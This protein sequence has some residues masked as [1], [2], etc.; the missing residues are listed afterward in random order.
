M[1]PEDAFMAA[2]IESPEDDGPRL[3]YADWL[4]DH[5]QPERAEFIRLQCELASMSEDE[6]V[7]RRQEPEARE[8][9]LLE[10]H[11]EG[12]AGPLRKVVRKWKFRRGFV[13]EIEIETGDFLAHAGA[14]L[15]LAPVRQ[16]AFD[17]WSPVD[18]TL[19]RLAACDALARLAAVRLAFGH[20]ECSDHTLRTLASLPPLLER[21]DTLHMMFGRLSETGLA[22]VFCSPHLLRLR[23]LW[24]TDCGL[25]GER[26]LRPLVESRRLGR[27]NYLSL[28]AN[29]VGAEG[30]RALAGSPNCRPLTALDLTQCEVG[31][32]GA[33]AVARSPHLAGLIAL[34]LGN[35]AVGDG[36]A[37]ALAGSPYLAGLECLGVPRNGVSDAGALAL[38][39]SP[40]LGSLAFLIVAGNEISEAGV[41]RL[42][43]RFGDGVLL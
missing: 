6:G 15:A 30:A 25:S 7:P 26:G 42:K 40:H 16:A 13:E 12:W 19:R 41:G 9:Q 33:V 31:Q 43:A 14:I 38:A 1:T 36:G 39:D 27:L 10:E 21:L 18:G 35:N 11:G 2:I 29:P 37:E 28:R 32:V 34:E 20:K 8:R 4:E 5:G 24:L 17:G 23:S 22:A 3:V